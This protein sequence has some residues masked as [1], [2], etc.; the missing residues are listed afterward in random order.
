MDSTPSPFTLLVDWLAFTLPDASADTVKE[1]IGGEWIENQAGFRGYPTCWLT[2]DGSRGIGKLGTG[3]SR[4]PREVHVDL[5]GGIVSPWEPSR[6]RTVLRWIRDQRGHATRIDC[7]LDDRK[8]LVPLSTIKAAVEAGHVV[9]RA[10]KYEV[11]SSSSLD[12]GQ[13]S[14]ETLYF[15][16][17]VS[18]TRLRIY[19]KRLELQQ[20]ERQDWQDYGIRWE[21]E[22]KKDRAQSMALAFASLEETDWHE[23][24]VSVL[25]SYIDFRDTARDEETWIRCR[26]PLLSW[27][28]ALTEGFQK[29]HLTTAK[30]ERTIEQ[31]KD[32]VS[33]SIAPMLA[34][35]SASPEAGE[36]W[37]R[38]AISA[39]VDRWRDHHRQLV[40]QQRKRKPYVLRAE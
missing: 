37:L 39:G 21:L 18:Q 1:M 33:R 34:V 14:G 19:D 5:S 12:S 15:G 27:W 30:E 11:R 32:W 26:A 36:T 13:L 38:D 8:P 16:S 28:E 9:T 25:R 24:T 7:V 3:A 35:V 22:L 29:A 2:A 6:L 23:L 40:R 17:P 20:K 10:E 31:V 4:K